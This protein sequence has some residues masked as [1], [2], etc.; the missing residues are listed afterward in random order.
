MLFCEGVLGE[1]VTVVFDGWY[2]S[3]RSLFE[4]LRVRNL[5]LCGDLGHLQTKNKTLRLQAWLK[6][7]NGTKKSN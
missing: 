5:I 7:R 3:C 2:R 1:V 4:Q 6:Y